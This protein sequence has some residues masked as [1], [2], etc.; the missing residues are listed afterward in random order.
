M[1][2]G[3]RLTKPQV[4]GKQRSAP[5]KRHKAQGEPA[6]EMPSLKGLCWNARGLTTVIYELTHLVEHHAPDFVI[7]TEIKLRQN[8]RY[9]KKLTETLE[10]YIIHTSCKRNTPKMREGGQTG[11][12]GVAIAVQKKLAAHGSLKVTPVNASAASGH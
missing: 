12:A 5:P 6:K 10:D 8:S 9:R 7:L 3:K 11:T 4:L 2:R 1:N